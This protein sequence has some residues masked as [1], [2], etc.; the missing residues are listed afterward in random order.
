M[1]IVFHYCSR[2]ICVYIK[3]WYTT[4]EAEGTHN[5]IEINF[6]QNGNHV[7]HSTWTKA[8]E[9]IKYTYIVHNILLTRNDDN[10]VITYQSISEY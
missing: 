2:Q 4:K 7:L 6:I 1:P 8:R 3:L 9:A 5:I 10:E